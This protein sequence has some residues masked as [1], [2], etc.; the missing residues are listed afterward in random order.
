MR[1]DDTVYLRHILDAINQIQDY[2]SGISSEQFLQYRMLQ[3][4]VVRQLEIVGEA[5]RN[6][7]ES[8]RQAHHELPWAEIISMRNRMIHAYFNVNLVIVWEVVQQEVPGLGRQVKRCL[9]G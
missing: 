1:R 7:S 6:L 3:D 4:A 2:T 5:A 9:E 8:F